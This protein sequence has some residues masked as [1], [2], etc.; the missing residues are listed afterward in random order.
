[1]N[2][3]LFNSII[4]RI[5]YKLNAIAQKHTGYCMFISKE[6]L[7]QE[8][9]LHLWNRYQKGEVAGK[10]DS[11]LV[12][13]CKFHILNYLRKNKSGTLLVSID[14]IVSSQDEIDLEKI[15]DTN[16]IGCPDSINNAIDVKTIINSSLSN[17]EKAIITLL[18]EGHSL[19]EIGRKLGISHVMVIK[20]KNKI[21]KKLIITDFGEGSDTHPKKP[22]HIGCEASYCDI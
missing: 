18:Q 15:Y 9:C 10:N 2:D 21:A 3:L 19:R 17:K 7:Y 4:Q 14:K 12:Q 22:K 5:S 6:D 16:L 1:M 11:Y 20:Y 8:M 13:S